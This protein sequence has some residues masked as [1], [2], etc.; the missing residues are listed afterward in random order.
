MHTFYHGLNNSTHETMGAATGGVFLL[1]TIT[2]A[3][4]L[5]EKM[6]PDQSWSEEKTQTY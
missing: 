4:A 5:V 1:L 2:Q 6:T 3:T